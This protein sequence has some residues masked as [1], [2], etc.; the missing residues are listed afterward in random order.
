MATF[1]RRLRAV[2][3]FLEQIPRASIA[4]HFQVS[5]RTVE[6][7]SRH[8]EVTSALAEVRALVMDETRVGSLE[9]VR[10]S[11]DAIERVLTGSDDDRAVL[12]AAKTVLDRF[13]YPAVTKGE[14]KVELDPE[15]P[16]LVLQISREEALELARG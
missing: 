2:P 6:R 5:E 1:G 12:E 14:R 8:P 16:P 7:W 9:L 10:Q 15:P 3:F 4:R 11:F 13:G